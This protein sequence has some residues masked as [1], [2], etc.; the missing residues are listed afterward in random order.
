MD[1]VFFR[2][3]GFPWRGLRSGGG[4]WISAVGSASSRS[5]ASGSA[6]SRRLSGPPT[7]SGSFLRNIGMFAGI[8]GGCLWLAAR[9]LYIRMLGCGAAR[10]RDLAESRRIVRADGSRAKDAG[11]SL[12]EPRRRLAKPSRTGPESRAPRLEVHPL[13]LLFLTF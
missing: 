7:A 11:T 6:T 4:S 3:W 1:E 10:A 13:I 12:G 9:W 2:G 5:T 8:R